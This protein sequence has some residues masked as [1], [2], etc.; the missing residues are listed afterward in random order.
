PSSLPSRTAAGARQSMQKQ[1]DKMDEISEKSN[2]TLLYAETQSNAESLHSPDETNR[3]PQCVY[4]L[5]P[6]C[7]QAMVKILDQFQQLMQKNMD[8]ESTAPA[9]SPV[10]ACLSYRQRADYLGSSMRKLGALHDNMVQLQHNLEQQRQFAE[11][12]DE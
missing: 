2:N 4:N 12:E 8:S 9:L 11:D 7:E 6:E 5:K 10:D 3:T 1:L